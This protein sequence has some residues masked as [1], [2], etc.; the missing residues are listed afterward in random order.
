MNRSFLVDLLKLLAAQSIV[1]H[2][3]LV[4]GPIAETLHARW[5]HGSAMGVEASRLAV[6]VFLVIAGFLAAQSLS[7]HITARERVQPGRLIGRR[8][9][10]LIPP[11]LV[12]V[13]GISI[14]A[15][16]LRPVLG[17]DWLVEP[18]QWGAALAH[19][20][21]LQSI[22]DLPSLSV[23]AW[24]VAMDLQL[25]ALLVLLV[26]ATPHARGLTLAV[27]GLALASMFNFNLQTSLDKWP[28]YFFG[29]YAL[30]VAAGWSAR[31]RFDRLAFVALA[32]A[33]LLALWFAPRLR[34]GVALVTAVALVCAAHWR[35]PANRWGALMQGL[36]DGSYGTFLT[37]YAVLMLASAVWVSGD[38]H[39]VGSALTAVA[40]GWAFSLLLGH[41]FHRHVERPLSS[42]LQTH[43]GLW[44]QRS[45][46]IAMHTRL[47]AARWLRSRHTPSTDPSVH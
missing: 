32:A 6:Q 7:S 41:A 40:L 24:Y 3:F 14:L 34:L 29:A 22:L 47:T 44:A 28:L 36:S 17:S 39:G 8:Y 12:A 33:A 45:R 27:M 9:L 20:L 10:R 42:W 11:Y 1:L 35:T 13:L 19:A 31:S 21:T 16:L 26:V 15:A 4:Y 46:H 2:H 5:P 43:V 18:A 25:Y 30:G 38:L 37:H 23:G